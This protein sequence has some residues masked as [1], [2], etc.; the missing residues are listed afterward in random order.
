VVRKCF[1]YLYSLLLI[2]SIGKDNLKWKNHRRPYPS[3][4]AH[5]YSTSSPAHLCKLAVPFSSPGSLPSGPRCLADPAR[6]PLSFAGG[7]RYAPDPIPRPS[8][9]QTHLLPLL[10]AALPAGEILAMLHTKVPHPSL[11]EL[12]AASP[13]GRWQAA[14]PSRRRVILLCWPIGVIA[15]A[16][17]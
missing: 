7:N 8:P 6:Q 16:Q 12:P 11:H 17:P 9:L 1:S 15:A 13:M 2:Y 3:E 5:F 14:L 10:L 4:L